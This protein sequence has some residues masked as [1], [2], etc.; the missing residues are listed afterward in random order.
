MIFFIYL[1]THAERLSNLP[2][3]TGLIEK[4]LQAWITSLS[5]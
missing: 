4:L 5:S 2:K 3:D 1:E